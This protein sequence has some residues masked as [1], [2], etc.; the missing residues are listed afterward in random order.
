MGPAPELFNISKDMLGLVVETI[1]LKD[2]IVNSGTS[3]VWKVCQ[4]SWDMG[5]AY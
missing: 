3:L 5:R 4:E 2:Q 1:L